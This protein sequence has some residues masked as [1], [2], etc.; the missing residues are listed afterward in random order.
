[1][2][3]LIWPD[4]VFEDEYPVSEEYVDRIVNSKDVNVYAKAETWDL[5]DESHRQQVQ[6]KRV[7]NCR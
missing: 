5:F 2:A 4:G 6:P 7:N 1:M 3:D